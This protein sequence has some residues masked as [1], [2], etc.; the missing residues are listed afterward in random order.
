MSLTAKLFSTK[1]E[2]VA[3]TTSRKINSDV[4]STGKK[5]GFVS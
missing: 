2:K 3:K 4:V 1:K 5:D